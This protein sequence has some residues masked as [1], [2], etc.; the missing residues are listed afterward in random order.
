V[1]HR[2]TRGCWE[3]PRSHGSIE[4]GLER[5]MSH[6]P[7]AS[8]FDFDTAVMLRPFGAEESFMGASVNISEAGM[9]L[10]ASVNV[11]KGLFLEFTSERFS[12]ECRVM[13]S[14]PTRDGGS[15]FGVMFAS[16][17]ARDESEIES[18]LDEVSA[19]GG[20]LDPGA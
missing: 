14:T 8:R 3:N 1:G 18:L 15:L 17:S 2:P 6:R 9:L 11:P 16:L 19:T 5:P 10:R 12:G 13:W 7:R 20:D 4:T